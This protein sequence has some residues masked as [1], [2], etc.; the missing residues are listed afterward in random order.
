[1]SVRFTKIDRLTRGEH[2]FLDEADD[3]SFIGEYTARKG[4]SYSETND[5]I[6]SLKMKPGIRHSNPPRY[7]YKGLAIDYWAQKLASAMP[8]VEAGRAIWVPIPGSC[9]KGDPEHDDRLLRI[10]ARAYGGRVSVPELIEQVG[11]RVAAHDSETQRPTPEQL[12]AS[13]RVNGGLLEDGAYSFVIF[14][15][16]WLAV[17]HSRQR[18][19]RFWSIIQVRLS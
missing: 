14:D 15:A 9:P 3:C 5:R 19:T 8:V 17:H 11:T 1:M 18:S 12:V 4:Y 10:L 13:W 16:C 6:I 7:K 2:R